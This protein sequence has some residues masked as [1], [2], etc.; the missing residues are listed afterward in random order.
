MEDNN[1]KLK[2]AHVH[3]PLKNASKPAHD[4]NHKSATGA[5]AGVAKAS[6]VKEAGK[7][8]AGTVKAAPVKEAG[9]VAKET[10]KKAGGDNH[11]A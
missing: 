6:T 9:N 1:K 7:A 8:E 2:H 3:E 10:S 5:K 4:L 11:G